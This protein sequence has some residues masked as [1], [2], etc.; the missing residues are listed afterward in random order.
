MWVI[1]LIVLLIQFLSGDGDAD[2]DHEHLFHTNATMEHHNSAGDQLPNRH[3]RYPDFYIIGAPKCAT[4]SLH[5]LLQTHNEFCRSK[6]KETHYF[7]GKIGYKIG[8]KYWNRVFKENCSMH[9]LD[10]T[11]DYLASK[12]APVRMVESFT[13]EE[14][15]RKKF[16]PS[17]LL[18][19][20]G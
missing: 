13:A 20:T 3:G 5:D 19:L 17:P 15:K 1:V 6:P 11:P 8:P 10:S 9:Y 12:D 7:D 4:T 18:L 16:S 14:M 2:I